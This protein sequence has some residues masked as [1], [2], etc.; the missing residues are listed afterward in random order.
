[1]QYIHIANI[2]ILPMSQILKH[3]GQI[4]F[5]IVLNESK[6]ILQ[7]AKLEKVVCFERL[8]H[9][10]IFVNFCLNASFDFHVQV[11][12]KTLFNFH[13]SQ[14]GPWLPV[15]ACASQTSM[16]S[17]GIPITYIQREILFMMIC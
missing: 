11:F 13:C 7:V 9:N 10:G 16:P 12:L 1:M 3:L 5:L 15:S 8:R 6:Y 14:W 2:H 4:L 17:I